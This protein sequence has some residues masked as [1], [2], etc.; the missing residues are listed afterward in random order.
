MR[1]TAE[2]SRQVSNESFCCAV[3]LLKGAGRFLTSFFVVRSIA[4]G[5]LQVSNESLCCAVNC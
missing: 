2:G 5:S 3:K 4:E 1:S